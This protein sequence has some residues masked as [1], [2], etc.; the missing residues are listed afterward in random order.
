MEIRQSD[1]GQ[2]GKFTAFI[3]DKP[4]GLIS[5]VATGVG[6]ISLMHT[7][8]SDEFRGQNIGKK[9]LDEIVE[10]ARENDIIV[11]P[12]CPFTQAMFLRHKEYADVLN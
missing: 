6:H 8:V 3:N 9:I 12:V 2:R 1:N 5:Y 11:T 7:E 10:Y 4:A